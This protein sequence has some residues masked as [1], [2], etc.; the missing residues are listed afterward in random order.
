MKR[1]FAT[2]LLAT[3][4]GC[5]DG[6]PPSST[7]NTSPSE[8]EPV[9]TVDA[10]PTPPPAPEPGNTIVWVGGD[11][12]LT[13]N[14]RDS[15]AIDGDSAAG[16][17]EIIE[18]TGRF[19]RQDPGAVVLVNMEAPTARTV[20]RTRLQDQGQRR[21]PGGL[22]PIR[23]NL[24][25]WVIGGLRQAGVDALMLAN[26]HALDQERDGLGETLE[27]VAAR[28]VAFAGAG[29]SPHICWPM[30][31]GEEGAE[32]AVLTY[33]DGRSRAPRLDPGEAG[34]CMLAEPAIGQVQ[35]AAAQ[36]QAVV[37]VVHVLG[38]LLDEPKP[39]WRVWAQRLADAGADAVILHG[40]HVVLEVDW[41]ESRGRHVP[42]AY[43][44]GNFV[45]DMARLATPRRD[46]RPDMPKTHAPAVREGLLA[47]LEFT[48]AGALD[49]SFLPTWMN[50]E[51]F[52]DWNRA[53]H[54]EQ[55]FSLLPLAACGDPAELP[56]DW[57]E[58]LS[59]EVSEWVATRRD[60]LI[61]TV[62]LSTEGCVPG[63]AQ[64]LRSSRDPRLQSENGE[65]TDS[66][67]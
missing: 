9:A 40:T 62:D 16:F 35:A 64:L 11:V 48:P 32:V 33:F 52:I 55:R 30:I 67:P 59:Q 8:P 29:R 47:R 7:T 17:A 20:R 60:H 56:D 15:V 31:V 38:E 24:P 46:Y 45:A 36:A 14:I 65:P 1:R 50:D 51:R 12:L 42:V 13:E 4:A 63:R 2:L 22:A 27:E 53:L 43:G 6:A 54:R 26:N 3:L 66:A 28:G 37:V 19:W 61:A 39:A 34:I 21:R 58:A 49:V 57:P 18:P 10:P 25:T 44:L 23:L 5:A 41:L